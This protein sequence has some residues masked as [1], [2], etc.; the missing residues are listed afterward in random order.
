[1]QDI[2]NTATALYWGQR[3]RDSFEEEKAAANRRDFALSHYISALEEIVKERIKPGERSGHPQNA[4]GKE[5]ARDLSEDAFDAE[6]IAGMAQ[7]SSVDGEPFD[8]M[9]GEISDSI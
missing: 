9:D 7:E 6:A 1:M 8:N 4:K 5:L 2:A 3:Y